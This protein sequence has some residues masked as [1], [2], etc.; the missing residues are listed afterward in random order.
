[1]KADY[2]KITIEDLAG[3]I[4]EKLSESNMDTVLVGGACVSLYTKNEYMSYDL[5]F[6]THSAIKEIAPVLKELG[7]TQ[8]GTKHFINK[9]CDY[10]IEFVSPPVAVGKSEVITKFNELKTK[11]GVVQILTPTDCV[12]D[13]LAAYFYWGDRQS[14]EQAI[15]VAKGH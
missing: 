12:K 10:F 2:K 13:R 5:D 9:D 6:V 7:F 14:L 8:E 15:M 11:K 4:S 1:M 3:L